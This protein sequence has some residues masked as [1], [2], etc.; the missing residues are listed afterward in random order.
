MTAKHVAVSLNG[1]Q[2]EVIYDTAHPGVMFI[3]C[4]PHEIVMRPDEARALATHLSI[5]A[6]TLEWA[7]DTAPVSDPGM[8]APEV[9]A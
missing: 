9:T 3:A 6:S 2:G 5:A 8:P 4:G 7:R 1:E